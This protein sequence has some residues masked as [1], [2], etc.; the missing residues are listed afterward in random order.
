MCKLKAGMKGLP[1]EEPSKG[2]SKASCN[3]LVI[4]Y[5]KLRGTHDLPK[6]HLFLSLDTH[7][8]FCG[9]APIACNW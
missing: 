7:T 2:I 4:D 1:L 5:L 6:S 9:Y 3:L 8:S